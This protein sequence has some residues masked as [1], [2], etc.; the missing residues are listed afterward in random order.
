MFHRFPLSAVLALLLTSAALAGNWPQ[1]RGPQ[2]DGISPAKNAPSKWSESEN[3]AWK[4]DLPGPAGS[5]PVVWGERIFLTSTYNDGVVLACYSTDGK[6]LWRRPITQGNKSVRGDEG[7]TASPSPSTD[8][9]HVFAMADGDLRAFTVEGDEVWHVDLESRYGQFRIAFGMTSTPVLDDGRLYLQMIHSGG[10]W[11]VALDAKTGKEIWKH[12][13]KSDGRAECEH[14]YASPVMWYGDG[15]KFLVTHGNDYAIGHDVKDGKELWR[16]GDL[17]PKS[18][19]NSTLRFVAS[20]AVSPNLIVVPSAKRRDIVGVKPDA[21]GYVDRGHKFEQWRM[22]NKTPD[23]PSPLIHD[24]LV[25]ICSEGGELTVAD[26]KTGE[27]YYEERL[28][29]NRYR[30]SPVYADGKIYCTARDG[31]V[32]VVQ[33]GKQYKFIAENKVGDQ[34]AASPAIVDG[35]IYLRGFKSLYAIGK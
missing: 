20:P 27:V 7:N 9:Q 26:A 31:V 32:T 21:K 5:T 12:E 34:V 14:S 6:P 16:V 4:V 33:A 13:R 2:N 8:G 29:R 19:Y 23:V 24:G 35:R 10:A 22:S 30:A 25:Y 17:N 28:H 11:V 15:G 3:I 1:W 18:S